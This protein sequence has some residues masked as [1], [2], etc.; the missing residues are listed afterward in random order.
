MDDIDRTEPD[1]Q[2][3]ELTLRLSYE[4]WVKMLGQAVGMGYERDVEA[5]AISL[6]EREV[7]VWD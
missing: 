3:M 2:K 6:L 1:D 4:V 5:Y 7:G